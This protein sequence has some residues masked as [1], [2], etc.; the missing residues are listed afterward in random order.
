VT[1]AVRRARTRRR[2]TLRLGGRV[3]PPRG[4]TAAEACSAGAV[5]LVIRSGPR[6]PA[7]RLVDIRADCTFARQ[8]VLRRSAAL[9]RRRLVAQAQ[10]SG[11]GRLLRAA[12]PLVAAGRG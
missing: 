3:V 4:V 7:A 12:S 8:F 11:N 6:I 1:L 5:M 10:F 2:L 9:R